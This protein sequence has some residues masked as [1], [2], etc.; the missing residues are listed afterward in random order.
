[1]HLPRPCLQ[2]GEGKALWGKER[3]PELHACMHARDLHC[4]PITCN[5]CYTS[6][7]FFHPSDKPDHVSPLAPRPEVETM[8]IACLAELSAAF[9]MLEHALCSSS[10][11]SWPHQPTHIPHRRLAPG[12]LSPLTSLSPRPQPH[13]SSHLTKQARPRLPRPSW[14][15]QGAM[16]T[17]T[18]VD[19]DSG[20]KRGSCQTVDDWFGGGGGGG[21]KHVAVA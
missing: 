20:T 1:M 4:I 16:R 2:S 11:T 19:G 7:L 14:R 3:G 6:S 8:R 9:H 12:A 13:P 5:D 17:G 15:Q 10:Q 18:G 21:S